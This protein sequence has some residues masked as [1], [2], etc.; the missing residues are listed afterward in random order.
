MQPPE[1]IV[2]EKE[3]AYCDGGN[4]PL[5]H[6]RVYLTMNKEGYVDCP[7]CGRRYELPGTHSERQPPVIR[8]KV[9]TRAWTG[10]MTSDGTD[11]MDS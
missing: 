11:N 10:K 1:T 7:Y 9:K 8:A 3:K 2:V 4:G 5:G 6:P